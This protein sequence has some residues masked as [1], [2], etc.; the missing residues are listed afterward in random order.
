MTTRRPW[1]LHTGTHI[2][3][4]GDVLTVLHDAATAPANQ[5]ILVHARPSHGGH[6]TVILIP[7]QADVEVADRQPPVF[8]W[9]F[10]S[11]DHATGDPDCSGCWSDAWPAPCE[12]GGLVHAEFEDESNDSVIL[13]YRCDRCGS[14]DQPDETY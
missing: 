4:A 2:R 10:G 6:D 5:G 11:W 12:C 3:W 1:E 13:S 8:R 14:T 7:V 9:P